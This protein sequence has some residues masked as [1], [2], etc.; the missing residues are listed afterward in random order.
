MG[1]HLE[2]QMNFKK[3]TLFKRDE[4]MRCRWLRAGVF[5]HEVKAK[6][7][8]Q[9][10]RMANIRKVQAGLLLLN[11]GE[12]QQTY[13]TVEAVRSVWGWLELASVEADSC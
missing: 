11:S 13:R 8:Q 7:I 5:S 9:L 12:E 10:K 2:R 4:P 3:T 6:L 1:V